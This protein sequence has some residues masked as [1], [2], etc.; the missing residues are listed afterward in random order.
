MQA[1]VS[2]E[3]TGPEFVSVRNVQLALWER[4]GV[5]PTVLFTHATGFHARCWD[6]II[7]R[8]PNHTIAVDMRGHGHSTK[9]KPPYLWRDF[10]EDIAALLRVKELRSLTGVG[11]SMGGHAL[12]LAASIAPEAFA[13]LVLVDPVILPRDMYRAHPAESHFARKRRERW[14]SSAEMI[15]RFRDREPFRDWD[16]G[17]F[18]DYCEWALLPAEEGAGFVL[19]C[20]PEVEGSIYENCVAMSADIYDYLDRIEAPITLIRSARSLRSAVALDMGASPT[21]P[22]LATYFR[23]CREVAAATSHFVPMED[24]GLVAAE[25]SRS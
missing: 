4:S 13:R 8:I 16:P 1:G 6:Q 7:A 24:P 25:I 20:P 17:V 2:P 14:S 12:A 5:E 18:H 9:P 21:A 10:G 22:D 15:E 3:I 19:A 23:D 11:H